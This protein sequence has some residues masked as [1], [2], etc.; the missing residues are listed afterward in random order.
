MRNAVIVAAASCVMFVVALISGSVW[1]AAGVIVLALAG[2]FLLARDV[3]AERREERNEEVADGA[4]SLV[5]DDFVPDIADG[6]EADD[7]A[8]V[9]GSA[10]VADEYGEDDFPFG[11][12]FPPP[13]DPAEADP[14]HRPDPADD[15]IEMRTSPE[16]TR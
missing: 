8:D 2:L 12:P 16:R 14:D 6:D 5:P 9:T 1:A 3:R 4:R 13:E 7:E 15:D 11:E 10:V